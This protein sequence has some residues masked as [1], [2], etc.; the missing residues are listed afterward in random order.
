MK[1]DK[2]KELHSQTI[3]DLKKL[4]SDTRKELISMKL[5]HA[6]GK[7]KNTSMLRTLRKTIAQASTVL[8]GKELESYGKNA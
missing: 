3:D 7:I 5:D 1:T 4:I 6:R 8:R 2:K